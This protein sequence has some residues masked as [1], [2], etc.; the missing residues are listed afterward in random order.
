MTRSRLCLRT[1]LSMPSSS[2]NRWLVVVATGVGLVLGVVIA[3][4]VLH[5]C[6]KK[7][8]SKEREDDKAIF[9]KIKKEVKNKYKDGE[10]KYKDKLG[11]KSN[12]ALRDKSH[13]TIY[14]LAAY[15]APKWTEEMTELVLKTENLKRKEPPKPT[16]FPLPDPSVKTLSQIISKIGLCTYF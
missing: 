4:S 11:N 13:N 14:H 3:G 2:C 5:C 9:K 16:I 8:M 10:E 15:L 7:R 1:G 12:F 6:L